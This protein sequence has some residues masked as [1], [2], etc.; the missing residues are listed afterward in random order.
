[1]DRTQTAINDQ[2]TDRNIREEHEKPA[3]ELERR[4]RNIKGVLLRH[5]GQ[6]DQDG[7]RLPD[8]F[9]SKVVKIYKDRNDEWAETPFMSGPEHLIAASMRGSMYEHEQYLIELDR[10]A[11][12]DNAMARNKGAGSEEWH[13]EDKRRDEIKR[14]RFKE[15]RKPSRGT[16]R[17]KPRDRAA[18]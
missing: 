17:A 1:M 12:R 10:E 14:D 13:D 8:F 5:R 7:K 16:R 18:R 3:V 9:S 11:H 4:D 6:L 15:E 2:E